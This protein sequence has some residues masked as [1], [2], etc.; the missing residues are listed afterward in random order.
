M[1]AT[2]MAD[3]SFFT[4]NLHIVDE[5]NSSAFDSIQLATHICFQETEPSDE[6]CHSIIIFRLL[7]P[8]SYDRLDHHF[9]TDFRSK[10]FFDFI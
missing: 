3:K 4:T 1:E 8:Y 2:R 5:Q 10:L 6:F 7:G 9:P